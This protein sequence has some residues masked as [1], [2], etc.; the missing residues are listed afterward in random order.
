MIVQRVFCGHRTEDLQITRRA[1]QT[2]PPPLPPACFTHPSATCPAA[3]PANDSTPTPTSTSTSISQDTSTASDLRVR[4][5]HVLLAHR[6]HPPHQHATSCGPATRTCVVASAEGFTADPGA[7]PG[8]RLGRAPPP[9]LPRR[10]RAAR[11]HGYEGYEGFGWTIS[12]MGF[13]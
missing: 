7:R 6:G 4:S 8:P 10:C 13:M 9:Y 12:N 3:P 5:D 2:H 1:T 11:G